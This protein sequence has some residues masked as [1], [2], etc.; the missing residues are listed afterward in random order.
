V[1]ARAPAEAGHV[2]TTTKPGAGSQPPAPAG[3]SVWAPGWEDITIDSIPGAPNIP[4][5]PPTR[6]QR[7]HFSPA[8]TPPRKFNF[9]EP[10]RAAGSHGTG[11]I[12]PRRATHNRRRF[13]PEPRSPIPG[14]IRMVDTSSK[15]G[16]SS[17]C[18]QVRRHGR[19]GGGHAILRRRRSGPSR[20]LAAAAAAAGLAGTRGRGRAAPSARRGDG[21]RSLA[22]RR[23][24]PRRWCLW[25]RRA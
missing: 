3:P 16:S 6:C 17:S 23:T 11:P 9:R 14:Q 20:H 25:T 5:D 8:G 4:D 19:P 18:D 2:R 13:S 21:G 10:L 22:P 15:A 1:P 12:R 7:P 24:P